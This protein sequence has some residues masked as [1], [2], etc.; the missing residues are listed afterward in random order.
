MSAPRHSWKSFLHYVLPSV[1]AMLLFSSYTIVDGIFVSKG[2]GDLALAGVNIALPFINFLSGVAILLSM[3][4]STLCAFALGEGKHDR[5]ERI[6]SQ[7]A[8]V[9]VVLS[10]LITIAVAILAEPLAALLGAG[11]QTIGY[12]AQYLHVVCLFSL[13]FI[14]SYCLEVMVKVDGAPHLAMFGV[15]ISFLIN[16]GLDYLF[17]MVWHWGVFGAALA[18]GLAQLGSLLFFLRYFLSGKSNLRFRKF[19]PHLG[20]LKQIMPLGIADCSIELMLGFLTLLYNHVIAKM[21]GESSLPIFAVIAYFSLMVSMIMQGIAQGMMPLVSL[22]VGEGDREGLKL[23]LRRTILSVLVVGVLVEVVCQ[24]C[25]GPIVS[26]LLSDGSALFAETVASL[27]LYALSYLPA[28]ITIVLAGYF[29]ALGKAGAS[30]LLSLGRGFVLLPAAVMALYLLGAGTM[31]WW[32]AF[33]G[34]VLSLVLGVVLLRL[35]SP[36]NDGSPERGAVSEAD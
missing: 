22:A 26:L 13:C 4:T 16:V 27:R 10:V 20:E 28:G 9:I 31:I 34:E 21:L 1:S 33:I 3:G 8:A 7:T 17:I 24:L 11:P 18:T 2:V 32:A 36:Q 25:P 35:N 15:G 12:S 5:A 23:Y 19:K 29:A 6:F 30:A 14:L